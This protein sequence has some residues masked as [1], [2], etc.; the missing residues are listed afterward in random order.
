MPRLDWSSTASAFNP[1]AFFSGPK[2][3]AM[4]IP[5]MGHHFVNATMAMMPGHFAHPAY[6]RMYQ[7]HHACRTSSVKSLELDSSL[8]IGTD[9]PARDP[10]IWFS[11]PSAANAPSDI[12]G[13]GFSLMVETKVA[14][15]GYG[16]AASVGTAGAVNK[17]GGHL[18]VL[19]ASGAHTLRSH[20]PD[21]LEVGAYQIVIQPNVFTQQFGGFHLN[22]ASAN[23]GP[24][25]GVDS[26]S[27]SAEMT[28]QQ[29]NTVI[30]LKML[31]A[32]EGTN[33]GAIALIL[34]EPTMADVRGCEII[35]NE[36]MLDIDPDPGSQFLSLPTLALYNPYGVNE[37]ASPALSRRSLPYRPGAFDRATPGYTLTIPWWSI[38]HEHGPKHDKSDGFRHLEWHKPDNYYELCRST[39]GAIGSQVTIAGYPSLFLDFYAPT[40]FTDA[41]CDL[42][43]SDATVTM[44]STAKLVVGMHVSC[45]TAGFPTAA[46][47]ASITNATTFELSANYT[48]SNAS[49]Q[50][51][52]FTGENVANYR[53]RSLNP[54]CIVTSAL[55]S[56]GNMTVDD[57]SAFPL[58]PYY[59]EKLEYIDNAGVRHVGTYAHRQGSTI[60]STYGQADVLKTV[61]FDAAAYPIPVGAIIR[62]TRPYDNGASGTIF[63]TSTRSIITRLLP[64][65]MLGSRDTN[66][67]HLAD[68]YLCMWHPNLGRP[69][70]Y[71]G[72]NSS[73]SFY[74]NAINDDTSVDK[75]ALNHLPEHYETVHYHEFG[76]VMSR[77]P[78]N[79]KMKFIQPDGDGTAVANDGLSGFDVQQT[80]AHFGGFWPGGSR[81]GGGVSRL[82]DYGLAKTGWG[83]ADY[84]TIPYTYDVTTSS[85]TPST[86]KVLRTKIADLGTQTHGRHLAF[87]HRCFVRPP[88]N[89]PQWSPTVRGFLEDAQD[90]ISTSLSSTTEGIQAGYGHGPLVQQ[91]G[92]SWLEIG[93][94]FSDAT[95]PAT[96]VGIIERQT[97]I[98]ALLNN[99]QPQ[100]QVRYSDGRR[101]T[102]S[103]GCPVRSLINGN[104]VPRKFPGD[105][106]GKGV[107]ELAAAHRFYLVDWWGNTRG[108]DV[109]K[110]PVR[111]F[112]IR[113]AWDP[114]DA[115]D[116]AGKANSPTTLGL[117][118][119]TLNEYPNN[120]GAVYPSKMKGNRNNW[121]STNM[122][123]ADWFNPTNACR[124][125]DRDGV[126]VRWPTVFNED[127]LHAVSTPIRPTGLVTSFNTSQPPFG[128]GYIRPSDEV[129]GA[130]EVE[131]GISSRLGVNH[132]D[133]LLS[134]DGNVG[135]LQ[136][137][138]SETLVTGSETL[139]DPV[140]RSAPRIGVDADVASEVLGGKNVEYVAINTHAT[141]LHA[142]RDVGQRIHVRGGFQ[143]AS[144]T[145][146]D[147]DL[148]DLTWAAH[149]KAGIMRLSDAHSLDPLGG[150]YV[151][152]LRNHVKPIN[153][154]GWGTA[155]ANNSSP[156]GSGSHNP[157][158]AQ[159]NH[160]D[161]VIRLLFRPIRVLDG[162]HVEVFR[163]PPMTISTPPQKDGSNNLNDAYRSIV[164]G[165][166]GM[167]NYDAPSARSTPK[168][169]TS[170]NVTPT[171]LPYTPVYTV[172]TSSPTVAASSGPTI[173]G[174]EASGFSSALDQTVAR[175]IISE[176]TLQHYR[177]D[178]PRR[179]TY[180]NED[181]VT[182]RPDYTIQPR[183]SQSLHPKGEGGTT[184]YNTSNHSGDV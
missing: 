38:Q 31:S 15:E 22:N 48:G 167:F 173:P 56:D 106:L 107:T 5:R 108:E 92:G 128:K 23:L 79:L 52:T 180:V 69:Y 47:V 154:S 42:T 27:D 120:T 99:D 29:V 152:E 171:T 78:F 95:F 161:K 105:S 8:T 168:G 157:S 4:P 54:H 41:T 83:L 51:I 112:G 175:V 62:L 147:Y 35:V 129:L 103:F 43:N 150:T 20:F 135:P 50:T 66:S 60:D 93:S 140:S 100:R 163:A 88:Y 159:K 32:D 101:M 82:D 136:E 115:Y 46:T 21:P 117:F 55:S 110:F 72:D 130:T 80:G 16:V 153:D 182:T 58:M 131:R 94:N 53:L 174:A 74:T 2:M 37:T 68:A 123:V 59:G 81:G 40:S 160:S 179:R 124:V 65:T 70:T 144:Q 6:Q 64:Q 17:R 45:A 122:T 183:Y 142:S 30:G 143:G 3:T 1:D 178:A 73:R 172:N 118:H 36:V 148:S 67:L 34:A 91:D 151:L 96:Y 109:R 49:N 158:S 134:I 138:I 141:S 170:G 149:P 86:G 25:S 85:G 169:T 162:R 10:L 181:R 12:H 145:I 137:T 111:G 61:D 127:L 176:N 90:N 26:G 166:Y 133:G 113:P 132:S 102:R 156:Y 97:S 121:N 18:I 9:T 177:S 76:Y 116:G 87:G 89:R 164:G 44:D 125:G 155:D 11:G 165:K 104:T 13:G 33:W 57:C 84:H 24:S 126:G 146:G 114:Q 7:R 28:G 98:A 19:E 119:E 39:Y 77:G 71:Y 139:T 75:V 63:N 14:Y 184:S